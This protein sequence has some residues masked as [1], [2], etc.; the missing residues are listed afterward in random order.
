MCAIQGFILSEAQNSA[1]QETGGAVGGDVRGQGQE[2]GPA[3]ETHGSV[4]VRK[5]GC[6]YEAEQED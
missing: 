4:A 3:R 6:V 1:E 2:A 5:H